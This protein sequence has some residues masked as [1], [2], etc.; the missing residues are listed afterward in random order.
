[1]IGYDDF[2]LKT[3]I[4]DDNIIAEGS[5]NWFSAVRNENSEYH[6][7]EATLLVRGRAAAELIAEFYQSPVGELVSIASAVFESQCKNVV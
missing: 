2:H 1:M 7:H 3:L 6:N 4:I 5:F